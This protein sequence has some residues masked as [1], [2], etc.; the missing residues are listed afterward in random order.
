MVG[1]DRADALWTDLDG[2]F[3]KS[4]RPHET[5]NF[6]VEGISF[7]IVLP[8]GVEKYGN[9]LISIDINVLQSSA[10]WLSSFYQITI[11]SVQPDF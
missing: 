11:N 4:G 6:S 10:L 8:R 1:F 5:T 9:S 3:A 2:W 7:Y